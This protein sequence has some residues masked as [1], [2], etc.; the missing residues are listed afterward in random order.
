[1]SIEQFSKVFADINQFKDKNMHLIDSSNK[2]KPNKKEG[3]KLNPD[4]VRQ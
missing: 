2:K 1:M 4:I 3:R